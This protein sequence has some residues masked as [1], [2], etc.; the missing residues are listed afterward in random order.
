MN[1][2]CHEYL[3]HFPVDFVGPSSVV[4]KYFNG[5]VDVSSPRIIE[6]LSYVMLLLLR[7]NH[8]GAYRC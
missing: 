8:K 1:Q 3:N 5:T 2:G 4:A 7:R 6:D